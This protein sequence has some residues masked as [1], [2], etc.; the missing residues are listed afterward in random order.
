MAAEL[1][2]EYLGPFQSERLEAFGGEV[3]VSRAAEKLLEPAH[4]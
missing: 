2:R 3:T 1:V 4:H